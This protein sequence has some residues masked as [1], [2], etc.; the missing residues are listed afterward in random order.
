[1]GGYSTASTP[2]LEIAWGGGGAVTELE[3]HLLPLLSPHQRLLSGLS[4]LLR[5]GRGLQRAGRLRSAG[6]LCAQLRDTFVFLK[7]LD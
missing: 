5:V 7:D 1:M 4:H 3:E 2:W 6:P